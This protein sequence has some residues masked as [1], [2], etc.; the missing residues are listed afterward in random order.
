MLYYI[1]SKLVQK[2]MP[3]LTA[4]VLLSCNYKY[5]TPVIEIKSTA[6]RYITD[7]PQFVAMLII[8]GIT[9]HIL[10]NYILPK[11]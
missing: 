8:Y 5:T 10:Q 7:I 9:S 11:Q 3:N 6:L 1:N 4:N 2:V